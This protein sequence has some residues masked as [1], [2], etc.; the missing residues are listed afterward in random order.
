MKK[1]ILLSLAALLV[2][3][4]A[5]GAEDVLHSQEYKLK[6]RAGSVHVIVRKTNVVLGMPYSIELRPNCTK[7]PNTNFKSL[8]AADS[9]TVCDVK[10]K[11]LRL[12]ED[13]D[14]VSLMVREVDEDLYNDQTMKMAADKVGDVVPACKKA[15]SELVLSLKDLCR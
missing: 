7:T 10:A 6:G 12:R 11:S 2:S 14:S 9:R 5:F 8:T 15:S 3:G 13:G 4:S 1:N